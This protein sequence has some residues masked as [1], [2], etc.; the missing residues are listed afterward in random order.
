MI[1]SEEKKPIS[2][3][4]GWG[5]HDGCDECWV[6]IPLRI[7]RFVGEVQRPLPVA[8]SLRPQATS[9]S[10]MQTLL[11]TRAAVMAAARP[12]APAADYQDVIEGARVHLGLVG[13]VRGNSLDGRDCL[14]QHAIG[15]RGLDLALI[16][17]LGECRINGKLPQ[18][19]RL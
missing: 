14:G 12:E 2:S 7:D 3:C 4:S 17:G 19:V 8:R 10:T 13:L 1:P 18:D 15:Q 16:A 5:A 11:P 6:V 9:R